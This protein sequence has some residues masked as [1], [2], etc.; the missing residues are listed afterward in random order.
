MT[1]SKPYQRTCPGCADR[2]QRYPPRAEPE[3]G[4][5]AEECLLV[6]GEVHFRQTGRHE[7]DESEAA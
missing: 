2:L 5:V 4:E 3:R 6:P 7:D 1:E